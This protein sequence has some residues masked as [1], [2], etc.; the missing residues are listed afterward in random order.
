MLFLGMTKKWTDPNDKNSEEF[1][2]KEHRA[3]TKFIQERH[4][5]EYQEGLESAKKFLRDNDGPEIKEKMLQ[6]RRNWILDFY[7]KF[8]SYPAEAEDF[9]KKDLEP[10]LMLIA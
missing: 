1:K 5:I 7:N 4:E 6:D 3:K 10:G 2:V 9:E 8:E